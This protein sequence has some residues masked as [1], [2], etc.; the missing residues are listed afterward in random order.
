MTALRYRGTWASL[1]PNDRARF[2]DRGNGG[3][4]DAAIR[5]TTSAILARVRAEGDAALFSLSK[6]LDGVE[7]RALEVSRALCED[8]LDALDVNLRRAMLHAATN[9]ERVHRACLPTM[10]ETSPEPGI[11]VGADL[12][13]SAGSA[14]TRPAGERRT[15]AAY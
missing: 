1:A 2:L 15:Q 10:I 4:S 13:R 11:V 14:C 3:A 5:D 12:T 6:E 8:A 9:I 7:L